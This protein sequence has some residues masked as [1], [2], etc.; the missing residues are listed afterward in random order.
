MATMDRTSARPLDEVGVVFGAD[1]MTN[2]Y[3]EVHVDGVE[4]YP[5]PV[6]VDAD[7][8]MSVVAPLHPDGIDGGVVELVF[9]D[10]QR[11][12]KPVA[13]H[14]QPLERA[15]GTTQRVAAQFGEVARREAEH[16]GY[17]IAEI[18]DAFRP[19]DAW[20][21]GGLPVNVLPLI[22]AQLLLDHPQNPNSL[23]QMLAGDAPA[24]DTQSGEAQES[25]ALADALLAQAGV[26]AMLSR[27]IARQ[28]EEPVGNYR[29]KPLELGQPTGPPYRYTTQLLQ[30]DIDTPEELSFYMIKSLQ[31]CT[32]MEDPG[33]FG[34]L[35]T[36]I[37]YAGAIP[38][39]HVQAGSAILGALG[40]ALTELSRLKCGLLPSELEFLRAADLSKLTLFEDM[41]TASLAPIHTRAHAKGW[42][43]T[44]ALASF[45]LKM[46]TPSSV[47]MGKSLPNAEVVQGALSKFSEQLGEAF[48]MDMLGRLTSKVLAGQPL[49]RIVPGPWTV[50]FADTK[51]LELR[52]LEPVATPC[53]GFQ[54]CVETREVGFGELVILA[55]NTDFPPE[56]AVAHLPIELRP[57]EVEMPRRVPVIP[58][59]TVGLNYTVHYAL[60][61]GLAWHTTAGHFSDS[62]SATLHTDAE[63]AVVGVQTPPDESLYPIFVTAESTAKT[64][65]RD[66]ARSPPPRRGTSILVNEPIMIEPRSACV[67]P[68]E[69]QE[70]LAMV[71]N[72]TAQLEWS[73]AQ[74][75]T[76]GDDFTAVFTAPTQPGQY[77]VKVKA[78]YL[79]LNLESHTAEA[80][81]EVRVGSCKCWARWDIGGVGSF[82]GDDVFFMFAPMGDVFQWSLNASPLG[83]PGAAT[84]GFMTHEAAIPAV[85]SV[86]HKGVTA[87][88]VVPGGELPA[89]LTRDVFEPLTEG[90]N[91]VTHL[92]EYGG[93][94]VTL[95]ITR[96]EGK[97]VEGMVYGNLMTLLDLLWPPNVAYYPFSMSFRAASVSQQDVQQWQAQGSGSAVELYMNAAECDGI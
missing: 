96:W 13:F 19:D 70:F 78:T 51:M 53:G 7:G 84:A 71:A 80:S 90:V 37:G 79:D 31:G 88:V 34:M 46:F 10:D 69:T 94:F 82:F 66:P 58:G 23:A 26:E 43:F 18:K 39:K 22:F 61:T 36:L 81:A 5:A 48:V 57:I 85:G 75:M 15:P 86:A 97:F 50:E 68:G 42:D 27:W 47:G 24:V 41:E 25:M 2:V 52:I 12:C 21:Q 62:G 73:P 28:K 3:A 76:P 8:R 77:E 74:H 92:D 67:P 59:M 16:F 14:V 45:L 89:S 83:E 35:N 55:H 6:Y 11:A 4:P 9:R 44:Q 63:S 64:G 65:L 72:P 20:L 56:G 32:V 93:P 29:W 87:M 38:A 30:V 91:F 54:P 1:Q 33:A 17:T 60:D 95:V 49:E 40:Y